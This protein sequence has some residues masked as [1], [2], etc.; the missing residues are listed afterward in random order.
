MKLSVLE[1]EI[2]KAYRNG[3]KVMLNW[4]SETD[5]ARAVGL[6]APFGE[7]HWDETDKAKWV[8]VETANVEA[9]VFVK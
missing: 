2:I 6:V 1:I 8:T 5:E 4:Y 3:A 7:Y 9:T